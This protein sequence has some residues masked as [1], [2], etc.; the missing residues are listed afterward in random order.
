ME[1]NIEI[2]KDRDGSMTVDKVRDI[3]Y[4]TTQDKRLLLI[5]G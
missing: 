2:L 5:L 3:L 4:G 1:K